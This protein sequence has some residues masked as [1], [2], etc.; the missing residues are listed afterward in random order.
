MA[1][2]R[3]YSGETAVVDDADLDLVSKYHWSLDDNGYAI[4]T[5]RTK[6]GKKTT[7][8]MHA[9]IMQTPKHFECDHKNHIRL[10]NQRHNLRN[11][12]KCHNQRN[13]KPK[14]N[15][16]Y[17]PYKGIVWYPE[18]DKW[19]AQIRVVLPSVGRKTLFLGRFPTETEA[20]KAYNEAAVKHFGEYAYLNQI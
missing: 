19:G 18:R 16:K 6:N 5:I 20:A 2:V 4:A 12:L 10:D 15:R 7:V 14:T 11:G 13:K 8:R 3:L 9:L 17:S 1:F